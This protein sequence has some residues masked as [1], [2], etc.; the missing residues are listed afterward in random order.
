MRHLV[1]VSIVAASLLAV[2]IG[3]AQPQAL[4]MTG[5]M[6]FWNSDSLASFEKNA[7]QI[8]EVKPEWI[9]LD[10]DGMPV[11]RDIDV[12]DQ[13][14]FFD[15]AKKNKITT[16]A[17]ISNYV[18]EAGGFEAG[19]VQ[20]MLKSKESRAKHIEALTKILKED[21]FNGVDLDIESLKASDRDSYS[22]YVE[23]LG[24][25][26]KREKLF[27]AVT[28]HPKESEPGNW[29]G[30]QAQDWARLGKAADAFKI[31]CYDHAWSTSP[32][33]P[34]APTA[35]VERVMNFAK[36]VIPA[37]KL[38]MGVAAYGYDWS[39]KPTTSTT[40]RDWVEKDKEA[41]TCPLSGERING[42]RYFSGAKA[43]EEKKKLAQK[44]GI[45][46]LA[47]WYFGSEDP[48]IWGK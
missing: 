18:S 8:D 13:K 33:G 17:M 36:S 6:V 5:W 21:G 22:L 11:K 3:A 39:V 30:P 29:D 19:R 32:P 28:V 1:N 23:E 34:I 12:K 40:W 48:G 16:L 26:L 42:D 46:G 14:K 43:F 2:S 35:W 15:I 45:R 37:N 4:K 24:K 38:D 44:L 27:M 7:A 47:V 9:R 25:V 41:T 20:K 31:M 10:A